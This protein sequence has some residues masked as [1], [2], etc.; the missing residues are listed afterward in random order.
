[1]CCD[2]LLLILYV[3]VATACLF[4]FG[5]LHFTVAKFFKNLAR[6][7]GDKHTLRWALEYAKAHPS[8]DSEVKRDVNEALKLLG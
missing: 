5:G 1:M 3:S 8:V 2:A 6:C 4:L 7:P